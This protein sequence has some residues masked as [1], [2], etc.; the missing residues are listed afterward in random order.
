MRD[1]PGWTC[2]PTT[3]AQFSRP[4]RTYDQRVGNLTGPITNGDNGDVFLTGT[5]HDDGAAD[6][7][8]GNAGQDWF[9]FNQE[10]TIVDLQRAELAQDID[11]GV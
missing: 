7:L 11:F 10:D 8:Q 5:V 1:Q 6:R 9:L 2:V 3:L 4:N